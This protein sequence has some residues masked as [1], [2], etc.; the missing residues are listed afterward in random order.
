MFWFNNSANKDKVL[1]KVEWIKRYS[2]ILL[3]G[4]KFKID[5][6]VCP[7]CNYTQ[8]ADTIFQKAFPEE[9]ANLIW[10]I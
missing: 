7:L 2:Y 9:T 6:L 5:S 3:E 1:N 10:I 8:E 4:I